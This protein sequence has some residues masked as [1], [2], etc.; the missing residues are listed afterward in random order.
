MT[1]FFGCCAA[2]EL[3]RSFLRT[4]N[5][6]RL[7]YWY[8]AGWPGAL[9]S[10]ELLLALAWIVVTWDVTV[11]ALERR[12]AAGGPIGPLPPYPQVL[13]SIVI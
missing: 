12:L 4:E 3:V 2:M 6:V 11:L 13:V 10:R 5:Y 8:Q 9:G 1:K 7:G